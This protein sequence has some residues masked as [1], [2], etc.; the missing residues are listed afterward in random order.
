MNTKSDNIIIKNLAPLLCIAE[1]RIV[2]LYPLIAILPQMLLFFKV[3]I[4]YKV[5][6]NL[7]LLTLNLVTTCDLVTIFQF[8]I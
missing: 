8:A 3:P 7:D 6:C 5:Q 4:F 1:G 2:A